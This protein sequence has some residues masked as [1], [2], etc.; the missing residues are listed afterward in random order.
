MVRMFLESSP[1]MIS[2]I[3]EA[4]GRGDAKA[5]K[6]NTHVLKGVV[7][8]FAAQGASGIVLRLEAMGSSGELDGVGAVFSELEAEGGRLCQA[9]AAIIE[10]KVCDYS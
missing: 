6:R 9:L 10:E 7:G 5:L 4:I 1:K 3:E 2:D 8:N